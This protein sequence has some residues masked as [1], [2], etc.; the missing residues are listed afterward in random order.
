MVA[1]CEEDGALSCRSEPH[2]DPLSLFLVCSVPL[3]GPG[4]HGT[5]ITNF[6]PRV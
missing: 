6:P 2:A 3:P 5:G 1:D 4:H